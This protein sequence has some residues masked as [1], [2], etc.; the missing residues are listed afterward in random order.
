MSVRLPPRMYALAAILPIVL[1]ASET[2]SAVSA[3]WAA[4][5]VAAAVAMLSSACAF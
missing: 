2:A 5:A 4:A 3:A 1:C